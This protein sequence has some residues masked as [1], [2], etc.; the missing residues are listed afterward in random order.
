MPTIISHCKY[1]SYCINLVLMIGV[2]KNY[3]YRNKRDYECMVKKFYTPPYY[4][5]NVMYV[6][7]LCTGSCVAHHEYMH[8]IHI[9]ACV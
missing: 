8:G 1:Y 9:C 6:Y 4:I 3:S 7:P 5:I 2:S